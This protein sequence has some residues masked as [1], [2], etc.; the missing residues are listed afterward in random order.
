MRSNLPKAAIEAVAAYAAAE[1]AQEA[2]KRRQ[3]YLNR[4]TWTFPQS[5]IRHMETSKT[6]LG[7]R[8]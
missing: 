3:E 4:P 1:R 2:L 5:L 8:T 6:R 7:G